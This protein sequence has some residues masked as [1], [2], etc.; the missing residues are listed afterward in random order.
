MSSSISWVLSV[1]LRGGLENRISRTHKQTWTR[2][3]TSHFINITRHKENSLKNSG[4]VEELDRSNWSVMVGEL[5]YPSIF[6]LVPAHQ[7]TRKL[8]RRENRRV[9]WKS[10]GYGRR[11]G[12]SEG[13]RNLQLK[14]PHRQTS[15]LP[16]LRTTLLP[17]LI[18]PWVRRNTNTVP[19]S[20][21]VVL[22]RM[23]GAP[24]PTPRSE[25]VSGPA[26]SPDQTS[27][28]AAPSRTVKSAVNGVTDLKAAVYGQW[29]GA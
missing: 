25:N 10:R 13:G 2:L 15:L 21:S 16:L 24:T 9:R 12:W 28:A 1:V 22:V 14:T 11:P 27:A 26:P 20:V 8:R 18:P 29:S 19:G 5:L 3:T 23:A 17:P 6:P 4:E 7:W